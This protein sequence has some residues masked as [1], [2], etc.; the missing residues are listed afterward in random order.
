VNKEGGIS[1]G[2]AEVLKVSRLISWGEYGTAD[3]VLVM[4]NTSLPSFLFSF[5]ILLYI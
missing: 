1:V 2:E 4:N 3:K 5:L